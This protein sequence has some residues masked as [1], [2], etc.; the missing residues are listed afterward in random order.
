MHFAA[1]YV[2]VRFGRVATIADVDAQ[3]PGTLADE[4]RVD[5][6]VPVPV[7]RREV[8]LREVEVIQRA[9]SV[10]SISTLVDTPSSTLS[11]SYLLTTPSSTLV[12][13]TVHLYTR[14]VHSGPLAAD[15]CDIVFS[16]FSESRSSP[17]SWDTPCRSSCR[18]PWST[19]R[20]SY[21]SYT[22]A[23]RCCWKRERCTRRDQVN[24]FGQHFSIF[25]TTRVG[26][27]QGTRRGVLRGNTIFV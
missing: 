15:D 3:G 17:R 4:F 9:R 8:V 6:R 26:G 10:R 27:G 11:Y 25:W 19:G 14:L 20:V 18:N 22:S 13:N 5:P 12:D 7:R 1:Q 16:V 23:S 21:C 2:L 24:F